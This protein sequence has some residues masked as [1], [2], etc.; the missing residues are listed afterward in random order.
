MASQGVMQ[1]SIWLLLSTVGI[2]DMVPSFLQLWT[3]PIAIAKAGKLHDLFSEKRIKFYK[4]NQKFKCT[5]SEALGLTTLLAYMVAST[6]LPLGIH[7][8]EC[9]SFLEMATVLDMLQAIQ[10][11]VVT[12]VQL[13]LGVEKALHTFKLAGHEGEM[14]RK[15]HW[16]LHL[17]SHLKTWGFLPNCWSLERKHKLVTRFATNMKKLTTFSLSLLEESLCQDLHDIKTSE[18]FVEGVH[19]LKKHAP[20]AKLYNFLCEFVFQQSVPKSY[21]WSA[22]AAKLSSGC[23]ISQKDMVLIQNESQWKWQVAKVEHHFEVS[24][25]IYSVV[26]SCKVLE[27][28]WATHSA[29][30]E[31]KQ[32]YISFQHHW[33][34]VLSFLPKSKTSWESWFLLLLGPLKWIEAPKQ[35]LLLMPKKSFLACSCMCTA[36]LLAY[37]STQC[38]HAKHLVLFTLCC[39]CGFILAHGAFTN[40]DTCLIETNATTI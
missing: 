29:L 6:I 18:H 26:S 35:T 15:H 3:L 19:L 12:P 13:Q 11:G 14:L 25:E 24:G 40:H 36:K 1:R 38:F 21:V 4:E 16:M 7:K 10:Y 37:A 5:A 22:T 33:C 27:Y 8:E 30:V 2:W 9:Q 31:T 20:S 39:Q 32:T 17:A 28:T 23:T 34:F